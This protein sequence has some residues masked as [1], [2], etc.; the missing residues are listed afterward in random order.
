MQEIRTG[1]VDGGE[2]PEHG[3]ITVIARDDEEHLVGQEREEG[4]SDGRERRAPGP[5]VDREHL[6]EKHHRYEAD[7]DGKRGGESGVTRVRHPS[8]R[9]RGVRKVFGGEVVDAKD[10]RDHA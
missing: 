8:E 6:A 9:R 5:N 10:E 1:K 2:R 7:T 3:V 4:E